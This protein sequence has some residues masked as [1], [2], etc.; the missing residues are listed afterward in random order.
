M[1]TRHLF[2]SLTAVSAATLTSI[3][4]WPQYHGPSYDNRASD[5]IAIKR[6]PT[7]GPKIVWRKPMSNGFSSFVVADGRAFT[8]V[9]RNVDGLD[10]D[11]VVAVNADTGDEIW[12]AA[13]SLKKYRG[14]G[15]S[16]ADGN[17]GGDGPRSTPAIDG[18]HV[19]VLSS[20]LTL[21]CFEAASGK[22]I[23]KK[24]I[25]KDLEGENITW[26]NAASPVIFG[27]LI[28]CAG[29]GP[30][31]ALMAINKKNGEVAWKT[32]SDTMTHATPVIATIH[33][34]AQVIFFTEDGLVSLTPEAGELLWRQDFPFRTSTAAS[35]VVRAN[36][37]YCSAGYGVGAAVYHIS[38]RGDTWESEESWFSK[39]N[40]PIVNHWSTPVEHNGFL[41]GMFSFKEYG[42]GP[43]KCIDMATGKIMWEQEGFG[44]G[45]IILSGETLIALGDAGQLVL[46]DTNVREYT[47][48]ARADVIDGKC[49]STPV[50]SDGR[51]Y[52]RSTREGVC[53]DVSGK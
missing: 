42:D 39:G 17:K 15:D 31:R 50:L 1:K 18:D 20:E 26:S 6:F 11:V 46:I 21:T 33:G 8:Q 47:E 14:G 29:G 25:L 7:E 53:I 52:I 22:I 10:Q 4:D 34:Q 45:N 44:P 38:K 2:V 3:A 40:K 19:Y 41:Y 35:P 30:N 32:Q 48:L 24:D 12:S 43:V 13:V 28:Y 23:W 36:M 37:V 5:E 16:G 49:W 51:L 9:L 27:D